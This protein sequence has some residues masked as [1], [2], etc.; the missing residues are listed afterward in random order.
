MSSEII[1]NFYIEYERKKNKVD[2][3]LV[4]DLF[5]LFEDKN[6]LELKEVTTLKSVYNLPYDKIIAVFKPLIRKIFSVIFF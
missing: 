3:Q 1:K 4:E 6:I 5:K 2:K